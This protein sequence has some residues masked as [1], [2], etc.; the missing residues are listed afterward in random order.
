[1][2]TKRLAKHSLVYSVASILSQAV[3]LLIVPI[4]TRNMSQDQFGQYSLLMS[5]QSLMAIF[6]TL[7]I[8]SGMTRFINEFDN[9]NRTKNIV[10]TFSL[11]WGSLMCLITYFC[12][13]DLY[14][15]VFPNEQAGSYYMNFLVFSSVLMCLI[16]IYNS[17]YTMTFKPMIVSVIN[18]SRVVLM[19]LF[20]VY[21]L[22]VRNEGM[23]GALLA[24]MCALVTV[25]AGLVFYD[26]RNIRMIVSRKELKVILQ[27]GVGLMPGDASGWVYSLIDRYFI[28][29]ILGLQQVAVY[30]MG[31]KIGMMMDPILISPFKSVFTSF[32]Y[33]V[34]K[35]A[36]AP[37]QFRK[38]YQY[39]CFIGW[40]CV[41]GFSVFA[42]PAIAVLSTSEYQEAFKIVPFIV[43][44]YYINGFAEFYSLGIHLHNKTMLDS[45]ILG[46]GAGSNILLNLGLIPKYGIYGAALAT[47]L[48]YIIINVLYFI[49]GKKYLDLGL[50]YFEPGK[51]GLLVLGLY[52]VYLTTYRYFNN[53]GLELLLAAV[54][55]F[56]F[57]G[58]GVFTGLIPGEIVRQ[59]LSLLIT[60]LPGKRVGR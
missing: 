18:F 12:G 15:L 1:M 48:S 7:G 56:T 47:V 53:L 49:I 26:W 8:F 51:G 4:Y 41:L 31:Y 13:D 20:S 44:S 11:F 19:L 29:T 17:Y 40:F 50:R 30:S 55:M 6:I 59:M 22:I 57:L 54:L 23:L 16:S 5:V 9:K 24:Q 21:F 27:Y 36:E 58:L 10:L 3:M 52:G 39:Y 46:I 35:E 37:E 25:F 43:F 38:I 14:R 45:T 60:K 28:K 34:Y 32:K 42:K 33:K 2:E